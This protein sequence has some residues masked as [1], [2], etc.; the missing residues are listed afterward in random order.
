MLFTGFYIC[1]G[2]AVFNPFCAAASFLH[3]ILQS[4]PSLSWFQMQQRLVIQWCSAGDKIVQSYVMYPM[5]YVYDFF[6]FCF[7]VVVSSVFVYCGPFY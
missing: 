1:C 4:V 7:V 2:K 5:K 3:S 6:V